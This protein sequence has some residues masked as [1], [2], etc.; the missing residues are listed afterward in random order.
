MG[1]RSSLQCHYILSGPSESLIPA[2]LIVEKLSTTQATL[3][4]VR[5]VALFHYPLLY[6][7][8]SKKALHSKYHVFLAMI[9]HRQNLA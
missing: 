6:N 5:V 8:H 4:G 1:R 3:E 2:V 9:L 7:R